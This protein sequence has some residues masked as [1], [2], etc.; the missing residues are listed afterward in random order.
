M[1]APSAIFAKPL[2]VIRKSV[3]KSTLAHAHS[4][5]LPIAAPSQSNAVNASVTS[6]IMEGRCSSATSAASGAVKM[7]TLSIKPC[8]KPWK[9]TVSNVYR[10]TNA[11]NGRVCD[12]KSAT[13]IFTFSLRST[14]ALSFPASV[15]ERSEWRVSL[16]EMPVRAE[17]RLQSFVERQTARIWPPRRVSIGQ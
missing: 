4:A 13:A 1:S 15:V 10:A 9:A 12:A 8:V 16:Q 7:I 5:S 11:V 3:P 6:G 2:F 17:R 14:F